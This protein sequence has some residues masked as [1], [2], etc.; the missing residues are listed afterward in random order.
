LSCGIIARGKSNTNI[1]E[2]V[3]VSLSF[4]EIYIAVCRISDNN[5][6]NSYPLA[7]TILMYTYVT[8]SP[9][10]NTLQISWQFTNKSKGRE[11]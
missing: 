1:V 10:N 5:A 9:D 3:S 7:S 2:I 8:F 11:I 6:F 4:D